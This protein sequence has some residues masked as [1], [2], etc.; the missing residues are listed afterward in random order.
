M[1][2]QDD[3]IAPPRFPAHL[4]GFRGIGNKYAAR[5]S[6]SKPGDFICPAVVL[7]LEDASK[8]CF[9]RGSFIRKDEEY[10]LALYLKAMERIKRTLD[11][12]DYVRNPRIDAQWPNNAKPGK[13]GTMQVESEHFVWVSGSQAPP[14]PGKNPWVDARQPETTRLYREGS[15]ACAEDFWAYNEYAGALM[16]YW[17]RRKRYKYVI[18]VCGTYRDGFKFIP[19]YAGGGYGGCGIKDAGGGPWSW[20]LFHEWGHGHPAGGWL[21][22][23]GGETL[24]DSY[25]AQADPSAMKF[26]NNLRRHPGVCCLHGIYQSALP[27]SVLADDPNW[28]YGVSAVVSSLAGKREPTTFH[29]LARLGQKKGLW[30][31]GVRGVGD[32]VGE[33]YARLAEFDCEIQAHLRRAYRRVA[34]QV[35]DAV[36]R[37]RGVYRIGA[38]DAP[39]PFG[40]NIIRLVPEKGAK[41]ITVGFRGFYD[42]GTYSDWRACIVAV[43]EK[44]KARYSPLWNKG[45]MSLATRPGDK[46]FWLTVAAAPQALPVSATQDGH[47]ADR[48]YENLFAARYPYEVTLAGC[49]PGVPHTILGNVEDNE[50][51]KGHRHANGGGWVADT[52]QAAD[53]AYVGPDAMVLD[54]AKVLDQAVIRDY[55]VVSGNRTVVR[56]HAKIFGGGRI[57]KGAVIGGY[58][59]IGRN[60]SG[61]VVEN[62][63]DRRKDYEGNL[64]ANY[65]FNRKEVSLLE[66]F[67]K[68]GNARWRLDMHH[69]GSLYGSPAFVRDGGRKAFVF[70]G[71]DQYAEAAPH[72]GDFGKLTV[73][74]ALKWSGGAGQ[75]VFD[76]GSGADA[77]FYLTPS[78]R[79]G[80][81]EV[82]ARAGGKTFTVTAEE[83][84]PVGKWVALRVELDGKSG[85]IFVDGRKAG[86]ARTVFRA[87]DAFPRD[88][89]MRNFIAAGRDGKGFFKGAIDY[90]RIYDTVYDDFSRAPEL[91]VELSRHV[92][93]EFIDFCKK[94]YSGAD[95]REAL[96]REK[97]KPEYAYY[98]DISRKRD[99]RVREIEGSSPE[100]AEG[101]RKV[102]EVK[103][104]LDR[105][106]KELRDEFNKLPE[107]MKE[108]AKLKALED[109]VRRLRAE[110][111]KAWAALEANDEVLAAA[112]Q[113]RKQAEA[114]VARIE[115]SLRSSPEVAKLPKGRRAIKLAELKAKN[116]EYARSCS[117]R[118]GARRDAAK[119][120]RFLRS[121]DPEIVRYDREIKTYDAEVRALRPDSS[122]YVAKGTVELIRQVAEAERVVG[123]AVKENIARHS[124][125][126][127][128]LGSFRWNAFSGHYNYPYRKYMWD[129]ISDRIPGGKCPVNLGS[130][131]AACHWQNV[132]KWHTRCDW[133]GRLQWE[134]D[135]AMTPL[136]RKWLQ[137]VRGGVR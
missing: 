25:Q 41:A 71:V 105:R 54:R 70:N 16:P 118:D 81:P 44:G 114:E 122:G 11:K 59:R 121:N 69:S 130:L 66:D 125:E 128:W 92:S 52:A 49:R 34:R 104:K 43:D 20:G 65:A 82:T 31:N 106:R 3:K 74:I 63:R 96:I 84:L 119:R 57:E 37:R 26:G 64:V 9:T 112:K 120:D 126:H 110:R 32:F 116:A 99:K 136:V 109:K 115:K 24:C 89:E 131:E 8:R 40:G 117:A 73:D 91:P 1:T 67:F 86:S 19:G 38:S 42:P 29:T 10:I 36:D 135:G 108:L 77:C 35:L 129:R 97:M 93:R 5:P 6:K 137:R 46:R 13:P 79:G 111:G 72:V 100:V 17:E 47:S 56:D 14:G 101:R 132:A 103:R 33:Y 58:S 95:L 134:I 127:G 113:K 62:G 85:T 2:R 88:R 7:R 90:V 53:T 55:A 98:E 133:D 102:G 94:K 51:M 68:A 48:V 12:I 18:T 4:I 75:R 123:G 50:K 28:G 107:T 60:V 39:H 80:K 124:L 22:I 87:A 30:K 83:P 78:G 45:E 27:Y 61:G 23:G 15:V 21:L 76:F